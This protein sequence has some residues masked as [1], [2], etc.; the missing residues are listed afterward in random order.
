MIIPEA[1]KAL[2]ALC[3]A[4]EKSGVPK[5]MLSLVELRASQRK[6]G[7]NGKNHAVAR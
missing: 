5:S 6:H 2:S 1:M 3:S 7:M 4:V